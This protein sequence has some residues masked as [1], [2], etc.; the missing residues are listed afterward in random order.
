M[1]VRRL[2]CCC[3]SRSRRENHAR[4]MPSAALLPGRDPLFV[5]RSTDRDFRGQRANDGLRLAKPETLV[6]PTP[7]QGNSGKFLNPYLADGKLTPWADKGVNTSRLVAGVGAFAASAAIGNFD[8]TGIGAGTADVLIKQQGAIIA[9]G[10]QDYMKSTSD[11]SFER[12]EDFVVYLYVNHSTKELYKKTLE[13]L[14]EIYPD[15]GWNYDSDI[16][17]AP[18]KPTTAP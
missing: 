1:I 11:T 7:M 10:G 9:S 3:T 16:R 5:R 15:V 13:L 14:A 17:N 4:F 6:S 2:Y 8:P 12:R 18:K